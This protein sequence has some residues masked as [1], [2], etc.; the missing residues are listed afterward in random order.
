M[1]IKELYRNNVTVIKQGKQQ[2]NPITTNRGLRQG[3]S[4]SPILFKAYIEIAL[5]QWKRSCIGMGI[6][7]YEDHLFTLHFADDQIV[8]AQD[9]YDLEFMIK[10]L[11]TEYKK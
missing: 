11:Y 7:I 5:Q 1:A 4:L 6:L 2:S 3:C 9:A 10:R 8:L